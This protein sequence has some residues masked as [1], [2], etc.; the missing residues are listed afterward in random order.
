MCVCVRVYVYDYL[1]REEL[2]YNCIKIIA[3]LLLKAFLSE[4]FVVFKNENLNEY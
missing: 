4:T 1:Q 2:K 3:I